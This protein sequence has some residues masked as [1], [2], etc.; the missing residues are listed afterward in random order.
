MRK[1]SARIKIE[2]WDWA[3]TILAGVVYSVATLLLLTGS[4]F[5]AFDTFH[6]SGLERTFD[7][8]VA[9][10]LVLGSLW[11]CVVSIRYA[12]GAIRGYVDVGA[13]TGRSFFLDWVARPLSML[14]AGLDRG[15]SAVES[16]LKKTFSWLLILLII[17]LVIAALIFGVRWLFT[18]PSWAAVTVV[19]LVFILV[20][21]TKSR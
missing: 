8:T 20:A 1:I 3:L 12:Y 6:R 11:P 17:A 2:G 5:F 10:I 18:I 13:S 14:A 21:V 16:L 4:A 7:L 15:T 9:S 19:L